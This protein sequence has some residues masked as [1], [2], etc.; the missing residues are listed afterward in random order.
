MSNRPSPQS[1]ATTRNPPQPEAPITR[2][3]HPQE[4]HKHPASTSPKHRKQS[5][6][7]NLTRKNGAKPRLH[8]AKHQASTKRNLT[9]RPHRKAPQSTAMYPKHP[10]HTPK[11]PKHPKAPQAPQAIQSTSQSTASPQARQSTRTAPPPKAPQ[12]NPKHPKAILTRNL[13][14]PPKS[15]APQAFSP[16]NTGFCIHNRSSRL[17]NN[18]G[19]ARE[20][21][22][23]KSRRQK[24]T[25]NNARVN[26]VERFVQR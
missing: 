3:H 18:E 2:N 22:K 20:Q 19:Q 5:S 11:H 24:W 17:Y 8:S 4:H 25:G 13:N 15:Q 21:A 1:T 10:K 6:P 7:Q 26:G 12:S 23:R 9:A 14:I 16:K